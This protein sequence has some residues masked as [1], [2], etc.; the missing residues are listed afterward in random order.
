MTGLDKIVH[1]ILAEADDSSK[2]RTQEARAEVAKI[3]AEAQEKADALKESILKESEEEVAKYQERITSSVDLNR[4]TA[5]LEA[6]QNIIAEV[7]QKSYDRFCGVS[8]SKYFEILEKMLHKFA[9]AKEGKIY[10]SSKDLVRMSEN[11]AKE[12]ENIAKI[13]GGK[14]E[15]AREAKET[16]GGFILVYG[17]IEEN[18][19]FKALFES[20]R[21]E[22]QD[23]VY[24]ILFS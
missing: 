18:C 20:N 11:F 24:Q 14:L 6:K 5:I 15:I 9:L 23:Q 22:L 19:S 12:V 7:L 17:G 1:Q 21:A 13:K 2:K 10:F 8:D 16:D 4:R 3:A